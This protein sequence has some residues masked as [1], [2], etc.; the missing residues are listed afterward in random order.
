M[1]PAPVLAL[2]RRRSAAQR[3]QPVWV[4]TAAVASAPARPAG[5][6]P[7]AVVSRSE[8]AAA[9]LR[10]WA[11]ARRPLRGRPWRAVPEPA[12]FWLAAAGSTAPGTPH[13]RRLKNPGEN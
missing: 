6:R 5:F 3:P 8:P 1:G 11:M 4:E 12:G 9:V 7:E 2:V 10:A 13:V